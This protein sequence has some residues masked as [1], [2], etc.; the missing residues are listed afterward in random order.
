MKYCKD[1]AYFVPAIAGT[2]CFCKQTNP[3]RTI[4][5]SGYPSHL[6][7]GNQRFYNF[8]GN[9]DYYKDKKNYHQSI[10]NYSLHLFI[11]KLHDDNYFIEF[12]YFLKKIYFKDFLFKKRK[13]K[14]LLKNIKYKECLT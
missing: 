8:D 14:E 1:C 12:E 4:P 13:I 9:C 11:C 3:V 5:T 7:Y 6:R 2:Y 10:I